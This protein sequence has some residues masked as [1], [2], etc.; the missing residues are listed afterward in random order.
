MASTNDMKNVYGL[1]LKVGENTSGWVR[2]GLVSIFLETVGS[3]RVKKQEA[4]LKQGL[5]DRTAP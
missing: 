2:L 4:H 1:Q 3:G 5:A